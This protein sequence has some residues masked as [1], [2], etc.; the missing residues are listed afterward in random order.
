M[1]K[2]PTEK[3]VYEIV[4]GFN[5]PDGDGEKRFE[6]GDDMPDLAPDVLKKLVELGAVAE[7][8]DNG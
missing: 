6:P 4:K 3:H 5:I 7:K 8:E 1:K 2:K